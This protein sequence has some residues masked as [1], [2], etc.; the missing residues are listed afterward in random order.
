MRGR[1]QS[2]QQHRR[3]IFLTDLLRPA[4]AQHDGREQG[5]VGQD[6]HFFSDV[7]EQRGARRTSIPLIRVLPDHLSPPL[8]F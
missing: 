8:S 3:L 6:L 5:E 1:L 4:G 7:A 2:F